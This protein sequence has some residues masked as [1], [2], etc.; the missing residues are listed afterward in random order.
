MRG[1]RLTRRRFVAIATKYAAIPRGNGLVGRRRQLED[2]RRPAP[3]HPEVEPTAH[4]LGQLA[5]DREPEAAARGTGAVEAREAREDLLPVLL[6]DAR[7]VV[8]DP[9]LGPVGDDPDVRPLRG[10]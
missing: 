8:L 9:E 5:G 3:T 6:G 2:E 1:W 4:P 10:V 7:P